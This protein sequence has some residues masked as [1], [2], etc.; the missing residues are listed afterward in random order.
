[1]SATRDDLFARLQGLGI[2]TTTREHP[3]VFTVEEAR[4][5]RGVIP[6]GHCKNLFLR[7]RDGKLW[8]VVALEDAMIDLKAFPGRTGSGRISFGK[9][10]TLREVLGVDPGSV[11]PFALINDAGTRV[12][13]VLDETM[14]REPLL[15]YHP[16]EN[17]ATT[18]IAAPD[19]LRFIRSC[20]HDPRIVAVS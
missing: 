4:A 15:N 6:G 13:V 18:T 9:A 10:D 17:T 2:T 16:L 19:L 5:L 1:M 7:D 14:M 8:L 20:G 12:N 3:P 11:T